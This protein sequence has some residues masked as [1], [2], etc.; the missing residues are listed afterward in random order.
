MIEAARSIRQ[1][2][3]APPTKVAGC[4]PGRNRSTAP[5]LDL[6]ELRLLMGTQ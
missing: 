1:A 6:L 5:R 4:R 2:P 3:V